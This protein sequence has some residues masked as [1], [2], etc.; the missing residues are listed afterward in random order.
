MFGCPACRVGCRLA[1]LALAFAA[2]QSPIAAPAAV[3]EAAESSALLAAIEAGDVVKA[4][5][6]LDHL[7][8]G[9]AVS[10]EQWERLGMAFYQRQAYRPAWRC[11]RNWSLRDPG[12][13]RAKAWQGFAERRLGLLERAL[14]HLQQAR[15]LGFGSDAA[16]D[17][18]A[19]LEVGLMLNRVGQFESALQTLRRFA[20]EDEVPE[21]VILGLGLAVLQMPYFPEEVPPASLPVV[22]M[23]GNATWAAITFDLRFADE[24]FQSLIRKHSD[25]PGVHYAYGMFLMRDRKEQGLAEFRRE[26]E[27]NPWHVPSL[28]QLA[29]E[30]IQRSQFDE[31]L[32]YARKAAALD[33]ES[34]SVQYALGWALLELGRLSEAVTALEHAKAL[35]P[36]VPEVRYTLA[37]AYQRAGRLE[38]AKQERAAFQKLSSF[39]KE[40]QERVY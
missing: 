38:E 11:F 20:E 25:H 33:P 6:L 35:D 28:L 18:Q 16:L 24:L 9:P 32:D 15:N 7:E 26:L 27:V 17:R 22:R 13:G 29:F 12:S 39:K 21:A 2:G 8:A 5:D 14:I 1:L 31:A 30:A 34:F 36:G 10:A 3:Q 23:A 19:R 40:V 4:R 37:R